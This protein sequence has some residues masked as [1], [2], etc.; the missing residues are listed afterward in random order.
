VAA[1]VRF[2]VPPPLNVPRAV[3]CCGT[4]FG[5][6][7]FVGMIASA[8]SPVFGITVSVVDPRKGPRIAVI[9]TVPRL[10]ALALTS[11]V[12]LMLAIVASEDCHLG[13]DGQH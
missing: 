1:A 5:T 4:P 7:G 9:V 8:I 12:E 3:N 11:P 13:Q 2:W 6:E 10:L